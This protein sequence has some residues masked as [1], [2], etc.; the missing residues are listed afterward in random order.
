MGR[1]QVGS[2]SKAFGQNMRSSDDQEIS[3]FE[4]LVGEQLVAKKRQ[5]EKEA[6]RRGAGSKWRLLSPHHW[7]WCRK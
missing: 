3:N 4:F 7:H 1:Y 2:T 5:G 6:S